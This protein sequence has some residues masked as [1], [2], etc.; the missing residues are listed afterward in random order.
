MIPLSTTTITVLRTPVADIYDEPYGGGT[1]ADREVVATG[2]RAVID[3]P[4]G[5]REQVAGGEQS[6]VELLLTCDLTD[7]TYL[8][9]VRD[10]NTQQV[11][12]VRYVITYQGSHTEAG[13]RITEGVL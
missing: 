8:D 2:V 6:T 11:Y 5:I 4:T 9:L 1:P 7:I 13:L 12:G 3:R 10:D